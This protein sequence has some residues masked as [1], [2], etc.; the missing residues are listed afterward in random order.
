MLVRYGCACACNLLDCSLIATACFID[1]RALILTKTY[2][3]IISRFYTSFSSW[4][5]SGLVGVP[6]LCRCTVVAQPGALEGYQSDRITS[7]ARKSN[8][9]DVL[10]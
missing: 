5:A 1:L 4:G 7:D 9:R 3:L 2:I 6:R 10:T 8:K